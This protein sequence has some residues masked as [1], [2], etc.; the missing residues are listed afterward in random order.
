MSYLD[1]LS[2]ELRA[3][4]IRGRRHARIRAEFA[5]HLECNAQAELGS[6]R[7]LARQFAD[8]LGAAL[9]R[10]AALI[11]FAALALV[12]TTVIARLAT[13]LPLRNADFS[14]ADTAAL[15]I[16]FVAAQIAFVAGGL[17]FVRAV[18]LREHHTIPGAEARILQ[19]RA[20]VG[21]VAGVIAS[22]AL[23]FHASSEHN[24][25]PGDWMGYIALA[26]TVIVS[27]F[28]AW[29]VIAA[30]RVTPTTDGSASDLFDDFGPL[31]GLAT[32][33]AG[34]SVTRFAWIL[35]AALVL[36]IAAVGFAAGDG[37]DGLVRGLA[38]G[39]VFL[40]C[41]ATLGR[42]LGLRTAASAPAGGLHD[43]A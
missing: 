27:T 41:Y 33:L 1:D 26:L 43:R 40:A 28:A 35:A 30:G 22:V 23:P 8:E 42:Y 7:E 17:G 36:T 10:N 29:P 15:L 4:G 38:E 34:R 16:S 11:A 3:V 25:A 9:A 6:P 37:L 5:D 24:T 21:L 31:A 14:G 19:R 2:Q 12:A 18:R 13:Y 20:A 32:A 39:T